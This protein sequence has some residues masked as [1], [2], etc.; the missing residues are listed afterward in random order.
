MTIVGTEPLPPGIW[1]VAKEPRLFVV[2]DFASPDETDHVVAIASD[3]SR[4]QRHA[5]SWER[6]SA[7]F[8]A[9][10]RFTTDEVLERL[11]TRA[12]ELIGARN[13]LG[14]TLRLRAYIAG[15]SH[16]LHVDSYTAEGM[17]LV[18]T[19]LL[20]LLDT[21]A[22]G[23]TC[24]PSALPE[25]VTV[26]PRRGRLVVWLGHLP[27]GSID[28]RSEHQALPVEGGYKIVL[29]NFIY[30][31]ISFCSEIPDLPVCTAAKARGLP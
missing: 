2:E 21:E 29:N 12:T 6:D 25:P 8:V 22:G 17:T 26:L 10:L 24:F 11:F 18:A 30:K 23:G 20:Y 28:R 5:A 9:E 1:R 7:S 3:E 15:E 27:D 19:A 31:P 13:E 16:P 14:E 4:L